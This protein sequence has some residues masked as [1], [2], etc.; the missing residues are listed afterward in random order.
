LKRTLETPTLLLFFVVHLL[1]AALTVLAGRSS[2]WWVWA[3]APLGGFVVAWHGS[4]QHETIHGHPTRS[5]TLNGL[6]ASLPI[7]LW[8]PYGVYRRLH[9]AHHAT[10]TLTDPTTDPESFYIT[11]DAWTRSG[12]MG[13]A[14]L[15]ANA[16][17]VGRLLLGPMLTVA[18]FVAS[19]IGRIRRGDFG[20]ARAWAAQVVGLL[21]VIAWLSIVCRLSLVRYVVLFAYPGLALTLLRSFAEH[22]PGPTQRERTVVVEAGRLGSLLFLNNNLHVVHHED[23]GLPWYELP[24]RYRSTRDRAAMIVPGYFSLARRYA[25]RAKDLP[26]H[27]SSASS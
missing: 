11:Q 4:L 17:L 7:G 6:L 13:R 5:R 25:F 23:P 10:D 24:A 1:W 8:M 20:H 19:E 21:L 15:V 3:L 22:R 16:T 18:R 2:G 26:V 9:L 14:L 12:R 27:P